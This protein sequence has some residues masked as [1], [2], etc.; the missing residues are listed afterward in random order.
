MSE[1]AVTYRWEARQEELPVLLR[2]PKVEIFHEAASGKRV[3]YC[4]GVLPID[5]RLTARE[6]A[7]CKKEANGIQSQLFSSPSKTVLPPLERQ[8]DVS[9]GGTFP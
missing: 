3:E 1:G 7:L 5:A 6:M 4:G 9:P 2:R 8:S